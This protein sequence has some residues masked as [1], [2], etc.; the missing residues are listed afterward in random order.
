MLWRFWKIFDPRPYLIALWTFNFVL[1]IVIHFVLLS[2]ERFNWF[3]PAGA[4]V[5]AARTSGSQA[6]PGS[7]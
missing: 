4:P 5:N 6:L 3:D 7:P 1:A 2:T